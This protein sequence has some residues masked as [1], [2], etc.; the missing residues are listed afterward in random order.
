[1]GTALAQASQAESDLLERGN[2]LG[3]HPV[4]SETPLDVG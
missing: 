3:E 4:A 2:C 1:V